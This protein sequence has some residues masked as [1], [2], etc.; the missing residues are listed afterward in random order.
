MHSLYDRV[1]FFVELKATSLIND[2]G[3]T[4]I[5]NYFNTF[6]LSERDLKWKVLILKKRCQTY[7]DCGLFLAVLLWNLGFFV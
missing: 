6:F 4:G 3:M 1:N 5:K 7:A 2:A